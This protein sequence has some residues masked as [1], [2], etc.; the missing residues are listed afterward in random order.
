MKTPIRIISAVVALVTLFCSV[1]VT[2]FAS[3]GG[4]DDDLNIYVDRTGFFAWL[5][6][7]TDTPDWLD[8]IIGAVSSDYCEDA[9]NHRHTATSV[10]RPANWYEQ[11]CSFGS[12]DFKCQCSYCGDTF[13]CNSLDVIE[14]MPD[15]YND[16]VTNT[17]QT[18]LNTTIVSRDGIL[19]PLSIRFTHY[20][21]PI[22]LSD[23]VEGFSFSTYFMSSTT[24]QWL[25]I[26]DLRLVLT[27][28]A[29]PLAPLTGTYSVVYDLSLVSCR[30]STEPR[31]P[32]ELIKGASTDFLFDTTYGERCPLTVKSIDQEHVS[33]VSGRIFIQCIPMDYGKDEAISSSTRAASFTGDIGIIG[34]DGQLT[35]VEGNQIFNETT[36]NYYNPSTGDTSTVTD[37][38]YDYSDRSYHLTT[39]EGDKVTVTYGDE[40][41]TIQEGD[42]VYNV[43]Y[44]INGQGGSGDVGEDGHVHQWGQS[45]TVP[46]TCTVPGSESYS[47][48]VCGETKTT[49][50]PALGHKWRIKQ[51]VTTKYDESGQLLQEGYTIYECERCGEEYKST[52][53][54]GPPGG[55]GQ[56]GGDDDGGGDS[57]W[58]KLGKLFGTLG[59][60]ILDAISALLGKLLDGL[61][62]LAEMLAEKLTAVVEV[63]AK[64]FDAIPKLFTG[65]L[66]FLESAF[67][68]LP[69]DVILLLTFGI[70]AVVFIG[71]IK[72]VRR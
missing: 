54:T 18:E 57:I 30:I 11:F 6:A 53:G 15:D 8:S 38:Y 42:T 5:L 71:I 46:A 62:S 44:V 68:F 12:F 72:A 51:A 7:G 40:N 69:S 19:I 17:V 3:S 1:C 58:D 52:D 45:T 35:K 16:Y 65:F 36:N 24:Y 56:S 50:I 22:T 37:W 59:E 4:G 13:Y 64:L 14:A 25:S 41:I 32:F 26:G 2:S 9:P 39:E 61:I 27:D 60:G 23:T 29:A 20:G 66:A 31:G 55:G 47:C 33:Y 34:D 67:S 63:V 43:Y 49:Q 70:A 48:S 28:D 21:A 10:L